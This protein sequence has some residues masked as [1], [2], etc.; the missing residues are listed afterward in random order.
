MLKIIKCNIVILVISRSEE[1]NSYCKRCFLEVWGTT[2]KQHLNKNKKEDLA[3]LHKFSLYVWLR[4]LDNNR[5][6]QEKNRGV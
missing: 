2:K 3:V 6:D 5:G 1:E 4:K